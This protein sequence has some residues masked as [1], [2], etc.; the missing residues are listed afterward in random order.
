MFASFLENTTAVYGFSEDDDFTPQNLKG[1]SVAT[2]DGSRM[3]TDSSQRKHKYASPPVVPVPVTTD[4][5]SSPPYYGPVRRPIE[6]DILVANVLLAAL[7]YVA[8]RYLLFRP[9]ISR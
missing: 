7:V 1:E 4:E 8:S 2:D 9:G 6:Y 3:T 5:T